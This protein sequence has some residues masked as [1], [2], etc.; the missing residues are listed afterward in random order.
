VP[1]L[2][3]T[4]ATGAGARPRHAADCQF[5]A[6]NFLVREWFCNQGTHSL[7]GD[8]FLDDLPLVTRFVPISIGLK[9]PAEWTLDKIDLG[10]PF[11]A[12]GCSLSIKF[13]FYFRKTKDLSFW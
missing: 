7:E 5:A 11:E 8:R 12:I 3:S 4:R 10:K 2:T 13:K 9:E 6:S 1:T